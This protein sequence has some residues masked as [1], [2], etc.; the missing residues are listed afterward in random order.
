MIATS[1]PPIVSVPPLATIVEVESGATD[2][3]AVTCAR[4]SDWTTTSKWPAAA[5]QVDPI[6]YERSSP[7]EFA[8]GLKG[9]LLICHGMIDDNVLFEDSVRLYQKLIELHKDD[10]TLSGYPMER[11]GF[12]HADSWLDEYKRI[13]RLFR[14]RLQ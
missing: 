5:P 2:V 12:V 8:D 10:F 14:T 7:I 1:T 13:H 6:A 11:H 3:D 4:A 9:A